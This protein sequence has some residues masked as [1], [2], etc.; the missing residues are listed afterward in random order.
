MGRVWTLFAFLGLLVGLFSADTARAQGPLT[1]GWTHTGVIAVGAEVDSWTFSANVGDTIAIRVGEITQT[2]NFTPRIRLMNPLGAQQVTGSGP[3]V[4]GVAA[5][6]TN[7]GTFTVMIDGVAAN[8]TGDYRVT[9][10]K[11][12]GAT[13]VAPGDEGGPLTNGVTHTGN[14]DVGDVDVWTFSANAGDN[15]TLRMGELTAGSTLTPG[16][17]IYG[18]NGAQIEFYGSSAVA[19]EVSVRATNSGTFTVVKDFLA[20]CSCLLLLPPAK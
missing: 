6:A 15:L 20:A 17:W 4:V 12:P 2:N 19:A 8:A 18:P 10:V 11:V 13:T 3:V 1:N 16:L 7:T 14:I 9:L 5:T